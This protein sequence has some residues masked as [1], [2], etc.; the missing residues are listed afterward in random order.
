MDEKQFIEL[1][2]YILMTI[3]VVESRL[4]KKIVD[5]KDE[6]MLESTTLR[7]GL[8]QLQE[9]LSQHRKE[10]AAGFLGVGEAIEEINNRYDRRFDMTEGRI[11]KLEQG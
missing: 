7:K 8:S 1:K 9:E 10:T 2:Q 11:A 4:E 5:L 6:V 3:S